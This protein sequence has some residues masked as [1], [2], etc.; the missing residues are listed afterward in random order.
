MSLYGGEASYLYAYVDLLE[1]LNDDANVRT[2]YEQ[3]RAL[4]LNVFA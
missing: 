3:V 1:H 2:V 4:I